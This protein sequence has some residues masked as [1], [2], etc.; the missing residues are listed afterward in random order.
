[1]KDHA[2]KKPGE[3]R[4]AEERRLDE[5]V[6]ESFP[7]SD[8][9]STTPTSAGRPQRSRAKSAAASSKSRD[10]ADRG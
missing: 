1:M 7:A 6:E 8:P 5:A 10:A 9:P 3:G 2:K 4:A